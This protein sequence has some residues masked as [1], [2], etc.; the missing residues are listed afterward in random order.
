MLVGSPPLLWPSSNG[1][2]IYRSPFAPSSSV[3]PLASRYSAVSSVAPGVNADRSRIFVLPASVVTDTGSC[4]ARRCHSVSSCSPVIAGGSSGKPP[5]HSIRA[6]L[7]CVPQATNCCPFASNSI[8][9]ISPAR[10]WIRLRKSPSTASRYRHLL[11]FA[12]QR[13]GGNSPR[14]CTSV[15]RISA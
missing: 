14:S 15:L 2:R 10:R 1:Q 9:P 5:S 3:Q 8:M 7:L 4:S 12:R 11:L 13:R 6:P